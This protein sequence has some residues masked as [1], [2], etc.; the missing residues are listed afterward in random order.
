MRCFKRI[1]EK[2]ENNSIKK[3]RKSKL[4]MSI[5]LSTLELLGCVLKRSCLWIVNLTLFQAGTFSFLFL[6][7]M[8]QPSKMRKDYTLL[9]WCC[10]SVFETFSDTCVHWVNRKLCPSFQPQ[11]FLNFLFPF[12]TCICLNLVSISELINLLR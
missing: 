4:F 11:F 7:V 10:L 8:L 6:S 1:R 5:S 9:S 12:Y 2:W 3:R